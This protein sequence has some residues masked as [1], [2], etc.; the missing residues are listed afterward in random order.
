MPITQYKITTCAILKHYTIPIKIYIV[1]ILPKPEQAGND[2]RQK[3]N[4]N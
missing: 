2:N 3:T 1:H 4:H